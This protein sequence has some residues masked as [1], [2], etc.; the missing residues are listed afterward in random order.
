MEEIKEELQKVETKCNDIRKKN[1]ILE[2]S[3]H[4][5]QVSLRD[6]Q[7]DVAKKKNTYESYD[8]QIKQI[9]ER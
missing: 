7:F 1:R 2:D 4:K 5:K 3:Y 9:T 6:K 8:T